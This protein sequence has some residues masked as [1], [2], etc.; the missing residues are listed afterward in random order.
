MCGNPEWP[1]EEP[2]SCW[3]LDAAACEGSRDAAAATMPAT[4]GVLPFEG[5]REAVHLCYYVLS[6]AASI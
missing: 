6:A 5:R 2:R 1:S 3:S 4:D